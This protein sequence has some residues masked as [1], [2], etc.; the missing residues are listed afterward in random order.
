MKLWQKKTV[1]DKQIEHFT[2]GEDPQIDFQL[3]KYDCLASIAHARM[4]KKIGILKS[5]ESEKLVKELNRI[6][7]LAEKHKFTI[8][9]DQEDGHTAI[10]MH[11]TRKLG[12]LGKKIH[13]ARSRNDQVLAAL[14]LYYKEKIKICETEIHQ[15]N[16]SLDHLIKTSG[17]V[18]FPG[19]THTRKA[20]ASSVRLWA[21][22][23]LQSM[24]DNLKLLR[25]AKELID[26]SPL[27]TGAGY[28]I[29]LDVD[30]PYAAKLAGFKKIQQNPLYVQN[31]RGKF[32]S[33]LI[34]TLSQIMIDL[35]RMA[36]DLIFF[37]MPELGYVSLPETFC[38]GS[39]IMPQKKNPD[40]L[41][42]VRANYHGVISQE[43]QLKS[44]T[45]NLIS[46]YHRDLQLTKKPVMNAFETTL[47]CL[48]VMSAVIQNLKVN[49][50]KCEQAL[51][52]EVLATEKV[53]ELVKQG[54]PFRDAYRTIS[55]QYE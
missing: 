25:T 39:S 31:S 53:Y 14:R 12:D 51:T 1:L 21:D 47:D 6:V 32:E 24:L 33:T 52:G 10:E 11:L 23:F 22:A 26:Q 16:Q 8:T 43:F 55:K 42:L 7:Q 54:M 9:Q 28:G 36:A 37:S 35:N 46:G 20:M 15:F 50:E 4:L 18:R 48:S 34:H 17:S 19:Y 3:I 49:P 29:P 13:T 2:V 27:G 45:A 40:V 38:T 30:R 5:G 41:E 44:M